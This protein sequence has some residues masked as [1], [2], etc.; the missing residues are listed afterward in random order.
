MLRRICDGFE[1]AE[2]K[3][4]LRLNSS[5]LDGDQTRRWRQR[6]RYGGRD[7]ARYVEQEEATKVRE[8]EEKAQRVI[9]TLSSCKRQSRQSW[10]SV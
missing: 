5:C 4:K 3:M 1:T 9:V 6:S 10:Q 2:T 7:L 8:Q